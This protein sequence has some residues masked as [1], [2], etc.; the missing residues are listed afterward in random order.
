MQ[1]LNKAE[2][3]LLLLGDKTREVSDYI[4]K[5]NLKI[6]KQADLEKLFRYYNGL[7]GKS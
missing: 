3:I 4:K 2:D 1:R 6:K 7:F 5:E